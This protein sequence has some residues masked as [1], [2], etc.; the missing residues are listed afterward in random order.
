M[1]YH[2][3]SRRVHQCRQCAQEYIQGTYKNVDVSYKVIEIFDRRY[4][5]TDFVIGK[6][7]KLIRPREIDLDIP[8]ETR[9]KF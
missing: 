7:W 4:G 2:A 9:G 5:P 1:D 8:N 6:K 3:L